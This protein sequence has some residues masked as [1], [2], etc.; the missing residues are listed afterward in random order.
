MRE[1]QIGEA[2]RQL[3]TSGLLEANEALVESPI[4]H[5]REIYMMTLN[6]AV[7]DVSPEAD[8]LLH[9]GCRIYLRL[10]DRLSSSWW[11]ASRRDWLVQVSCR[12]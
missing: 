5:E 8:P 2:L 6:D 1:L 3:R 10:N 9:H 11:Y 7:V 12:A 4:Y